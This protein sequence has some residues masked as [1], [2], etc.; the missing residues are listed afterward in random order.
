MGEYGQV[1]ASAP[2]V[3]LQLP[4][5]SAPRCHV[6]RRLLANQQ[7]WAVLVRRS[8][9][10]QA[11]H[12]RADNS[13]F[14]FSAS[15]LTLL[16]TVVRHGATCAR[17]GVGSVLYSIFVP[18]PPPMATTPWQR[19][20]LPSRCLLVCCLTRSCTL[21][22]GNTSNRPHNACLLAPTGASVLPGWQA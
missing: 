21:K 13:L 4:R 14:Q 11:L 16:L 9:V 7:Q 8:H 1:L 5:L 20:S 19:P 2:A 12:H 6:V 15:L 18:P 17:P 10:C 3:C 22:Q